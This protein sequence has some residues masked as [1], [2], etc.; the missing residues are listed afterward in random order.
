MDLMVV[1]III[2]IM[3]VHVVVI[4]IIGNVYLKVRELDMM[5]VIIIL[6]SSVIYGDNTALERLCGAV[7]L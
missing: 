6:D 4:V 3:V 1:V 7:G 5:V 2:S